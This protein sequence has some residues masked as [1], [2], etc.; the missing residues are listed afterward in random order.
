MFQ[1]TNVQRK[2]FGLEP[3]KTGWHKIP[4][5]GD[6]RENSFLYFDNDV[7]KK[8]IVSND[9]M[10][11]EYQYCE[12]TEN[13]ELLL[14]KTKKGKPQKLTSSTLERR[15]PLGVSLF[16]G[17]DGR[18]II[19][20]YDTEKI[21][22]DSDWEIDVK[23]LDKSIADTVEE[24]IEKSKENHFD[25]IKVFQNEKRNNVKYKSG[26]FFSF[27]IGRSQYGFGRVLL[28]VHKLR[29]KR[30]VDSNHGLQL[31]MGAPVLVN[32]Y[33]YISDTIKVDLDLLKTMPPLPSDYIMDHNLFYGQYEIIGSE[34][35]DSSELDF[36][37]SYGSSIVGGNEN[38]LFLQWGLIHLEI[39]RKQ[40]N[41]YLSGEI[42]HLEKE[43]PSRYIN[44]P[45]GFYSIG[46][47]PRYY[48]DDIL[49]TIKGG[50][51][52]FK[53]SESYKSEFDLRNP[54]NKKIKDEIFKAF[55]LNPKV[56]YEKNAVLAK[57]EDFFGIIK[58]L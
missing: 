21:F 57:T 35:L 17:K 53:T 4:L 49:N 14:P 56:S 34:E 3:L 32:I 42:E 18:I 46:Y 28:D 51:F 6:P 7:L 31:L 27:K 8:H 36:P 12:E 19:E 48:R 39:K 29:K 54:R 22:Y 44:N 15:K 10:Y 33:G 1:L 2:Y 40:F 41:K 58:K 5:K 45:Y 24:F 20:N 47:S 11:D 37:V 43:S 52:N 16:V 30:L 25:E 38:T 13:K 55:G 9:D 26:D 23:A 50:R